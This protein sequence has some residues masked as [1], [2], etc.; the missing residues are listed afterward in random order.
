MGDIL[1]QKVR[2]LRIYLRAALSQQNVPRVILLPLIAC[3]AAAAPTD[4][5]V[6]V[7]QVEGKVGNNGCNICEMYITICGGVD[8][9]CCQS[10]LLN[11]SG[12]DDWKQNSL[13]VF[14]GS[15]LGTC[16]NF[17]IKDGHPTSLGIQHQLAGGVKIEYWNI[18]FSDGSVQNCPDGHVHDGADFTTLYTCVA[19]KS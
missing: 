10:D 6:F 8:G 16:N 2:H 12:V 19:G 17:P 14:T 4:D 3:L 9:I 18:R 7:T 13:N 11:N 1:N 5:Y 15:T